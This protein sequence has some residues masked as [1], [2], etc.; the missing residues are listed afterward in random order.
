MHC[1]CRRPLMFVMLVHVSH[2]PEVHIIGNMSSLLHQLEL[3]HSFRSILIVA[4]TSKH[5]R[6]NV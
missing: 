1:R 4:E 2:R 3:Q 5:M 6:K